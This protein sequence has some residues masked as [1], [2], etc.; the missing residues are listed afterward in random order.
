MSSQGSLRLLPPF[1]V[2]VAQ[3]I[4]I[5]IPKM[6][7]GPP[8]L[9]NTKKFTTVQSQNNAVTLK[10]GQNKYIYQYHTVTVTYPAVTKSNVTKA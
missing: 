7:G 9:H 1:P 8:D 4:P 5:N 3:R 6:S 2:D 10:E